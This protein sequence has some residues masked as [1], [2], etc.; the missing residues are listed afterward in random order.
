MITKMDLPEANKLNLRLA[1]FDQSK[2]YI[3]K[4]IK[5]PKRAAEHKDLLQYPMQVLFGTFN[6][7]KSLVDDVTMTKTYSDATGK[8]YD[9]FFGDSSSGYSNYKKYTSYY[10]K[11]RQ[12]DSSPY[13]K[14][15]ILKNYNGYSNQSY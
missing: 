7:A 10:D 12:Y 15:F 2:A 5:D 9:A 6:Q 14:D 8:L 11:I 3:D 4:A 13:V 1:L